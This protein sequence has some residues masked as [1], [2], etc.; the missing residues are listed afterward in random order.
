MI[1]LG[2]VTNFKNSRDDVRDEW[3]HPINHDERDVI[4]NLIFDFSQGNGNKK[5]FLLSGDVHCAASFQLRK[6][7]SGAPCIPA[8]LQRHYLCEKTCLPG[9]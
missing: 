5:V 1:D 4:L 6:K 3:D 2:E 7:E 8:Y 9:W